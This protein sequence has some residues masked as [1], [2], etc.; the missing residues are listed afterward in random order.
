MMSGSS[1]T[2]YN[3]DD[4]V[5]IDANLNVYNS[6]TVDALTGITSFV[7][8]TGG[9]LVPAFEIDPCE[10]Q[11]VMMSGS[12][13]T[14]YNPD[15]T[16]YID[17]NLNVYNS[18]TIDAL[19]GITSFVCYTGGDLVP[20]FEIDPCEK[21]IIMMSGTTISSINTTDTVFID[22]NLNVSNQ[23]TVDQVTGLTSFNFYTGGNMIRTANID[24]Y[25]NIMA[26]GT[27]T[28]TEIS[29]TN[30][31]I[32][33]YFKSI[34]TPY[35]GSLITINSIRGK[36]GYSGWSSTGSTTLTINNNKVTED[37]S[38][39]TSISNKYTSTNFPTILSTIPSNGSFKIF[40][41][42]DVSLYGTQFDIDFFIIN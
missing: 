40:F 42:N 18:F 11:L 35:T 9:D 10:K 13:I 26:T 2:S 1:I 3:P 16:V 31:I 24:I 6:L 20:A 25:G 39:F 22:A 19:T 23:L 17:A 32:N 34:A 33:T 5:Y 15:D 28:I 37:S 41:S 14:S 8:Y 7:C 30:I 4:T 29:T 27:A 38:V 36:I 12:S 21:Q